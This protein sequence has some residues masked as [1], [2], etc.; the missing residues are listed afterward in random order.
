[1]LNEFNKPGF[2]GGHIANGSVIVVKD[3]FV[4][5]LHGNNKVQKRFVC[6]ILQYLMN[7][8]KLFQTLLKIF[9]D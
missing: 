8:Q 9:Q 1:M 3:H 4:Y 7:V 2:P 5:I 6:Y